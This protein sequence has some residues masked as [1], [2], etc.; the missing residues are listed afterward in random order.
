MRWLLVGIWERGLIID[1]GLE[2][3]DSTLE[4]CFHAIEVVAELD[5]FAVELLVAAVLVREQ[6]FELMNAIGK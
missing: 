1:A 4:T 2:L 6:F 5:D 3:I